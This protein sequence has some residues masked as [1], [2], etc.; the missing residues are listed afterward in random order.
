MSDLF[1]FAKITDF[2]KRAGWTAE[3]V[4]D[5]TTAL[6][7]ASE[8]NLLVLDLNFA[9]AD[10]L[11]LIPE[12]KSRGARVIGFVSHVQ[13]DVKD[14]AVQAGCDQVFARSAFAQNFQA[15]LQDNNSREA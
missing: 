4:Q 5:R 1:F 13:T 10:P 11:S 9:Q 14:A 7:G 12:L 3:M 8:G 6:R 15:I 2:A